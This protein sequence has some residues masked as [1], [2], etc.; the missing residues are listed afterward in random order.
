[1]DRAGWK[2]TDFGPMKAYASGVMEDDGQDAALSEHEAQLAAARRELD[3]KFRA[4]EA[5]AS[6][7]LFRDLVQRF[8]VSPGIADRVKRFS[9]FFPPALT[10]SD[11]VYPILRLVV[12]SIDQA[13]GTYGLKQKS[14]GSMYIKLLLLQKTHPD[15]SRIANW[16]D[17]T[18]QGSSGRVGSAVVGEFADVLMEVL[19]SRV[20]SSPSSLTIGDV[21][22][23]LDR[24]ARAPGNDAQAKV[25]EEEIFRLSALEQ[26]WLVRIIL[27]DMKIGARAPR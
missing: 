22:G 3:A 17:P 25:F 6:M 21:N 26:K 27:K 1:M 4:K 5:K 10:Q 7:F 12:P 16:K 13:R 24:L 2:K 9:S 20:S 14:I 19:G 11:S 8:E 15:A 23:L 18:R